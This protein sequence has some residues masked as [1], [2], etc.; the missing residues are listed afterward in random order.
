[1]ESYLS[2]DAIIGAALASEAE[3]IHPGY[4]FLSERPA[5]AEACIAAGIVFVG[6][7]PATLLGLGDKLHARRAAQRVG[8]PIVPGTLEPAA[9]DRPDPL[10]ALLAEA[11]IVGFPLMVKAAAGGGG[12]GMRAVDR[13]TE[14]PAALVAASHEASMAFG[15]ASVYLERRIDGARHVEVQLLGDAWGA[16]VALGERDC[17]IQRRHQKLVEEAPAPGLDPVFRRRLHE[18]ATDVARAVGLRNAATAEF[19]V[20]PDGQAWFLE[21][22]ARLQVEHGVTELVT[23]LDL[24]Q[25]QLW[26]AAG[27]TLSAAVQRA[28]AQ[29]AY[30]A[31]HAIEVRLSAEDP[32]RAFAPVPGRIGRWRP[33]TGHGIRMDDWVEDGS[34]IGGDYDP[35]LGK[36]LVVDADRDR[37]IE[38]MTEALDVLEVT[39]IQTTLPFDR[40]LMADAAFRAGDLSTDFVDRR[41]LPGPQRDLAAA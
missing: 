38:R 34:R 27:A 9:I 3:A 4:G 23:G 39:G 35:L 19:L 37:A 30:P 17:S 32:G 22:N 26:I 21:V 25:E 28:A 29:A 2:V 8:V 41:W 36:L 33:P 20:G 12:R 5:L 18:M 10:A 40:W 16:I 1:M 31:Q 14:L 24:V 6:P 7:A 15:D 11:E 13:S